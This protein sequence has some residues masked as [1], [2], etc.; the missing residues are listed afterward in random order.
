MIRNHL[1]PKNSLLDNTLNMSWFNTSIP[2]PLPGQRV[3]STIAHLHPG[4]NIDD[5]IPSILVS[6]D[7]ADQSDMGVLGV[8]DCLAITNGSRK[9]ARGENTVEFG[10]QDWCHNSAAH[11]AA[12]VA[13]DEYHGGLVDVD[14]AGKLRC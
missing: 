6:P 1:P 2:N 14:C 5:Y 4:W 8:V 3:R 12:A 13:A 7:M 10:F 9:P 11:V